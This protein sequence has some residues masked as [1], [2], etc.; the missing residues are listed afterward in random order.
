MTLKLTE[1]SDE[2]K[3]KKNSKNSSLFYLSKHGQTGESFE[4][5]QAGIDHAEGIES[6]VRGEFF[7]DPIGRVC[8]TIVEGQLGNLQKVRMRKNA[9]ISGHWSGPPF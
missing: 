2:M 4:G 6:T 8:P 9:W 5:R 7:A 1:K 3:E